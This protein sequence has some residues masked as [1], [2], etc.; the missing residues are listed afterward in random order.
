MRI[1]QNGLYRVAYEPVKVC[2]VPGVLIRELTGSGLP[3]YCISMN[4]ADACQFDD[5]EPGCGRIR[6][7]SGAEPDSKFAFPIFNLNEVRRPDWSTKRRAPNDDGHSGVASPNPDPS[8][9][10]HERLPAVRTASLMFGVHKC[11]YHASLFPKEPTLRILYMVGPGL[12]NLKISPD[13]AVEIQSDVAVSGMGQLG[14]GVQV[15]RDDLAQN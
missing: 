5:L 14:L 6:F 3:D 15:T 1:A 10:L 8:L 2:G 4:G 11:I 13:R 7:E 12:P 9:S